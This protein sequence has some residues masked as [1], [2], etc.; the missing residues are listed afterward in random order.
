MIQDGKGHLL[1]KPALEELPKWLHRV[2]S[3]VGSTAWT[4]VCP[5][6]ILESRVLCRNIAI[7]SFHRSNRR[8]VRTWVDKVERAIHEGR[9]RK[10]SLYGLINVQNIR[11]LVQRIRV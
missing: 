9:V 3:S 4:L 5:D 7:V 8:D 1:L 6:S 10:A 2:F 11:M